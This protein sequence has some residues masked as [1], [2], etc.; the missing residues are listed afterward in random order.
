MASPRTVLI[1]ILAAA[2]AALG[3]GCAAQ[4]DK[5]PVLSAS[6]LES[7]PAA[8]GNSPAA[9]LEFFDQL[10]EQKLVCHDD[11]VHAVLLL[12][13][14]DGARSF[15]QRVDQARK[16]GLIDAA[17]DRPAREAV[18]IG[19]VSRM[20]V[21]VVD[22]PATTGRLSQERAVSRLVTRGWLPAQ[23]KSYQGLTGAQFVTL[24][25][26]ARDQL[27]SSGRTPPPMAAAEQ[28]APD[29]PVARPRPEPLP[30]VAA[31][32]ERPAAAA[33][34]P[35]P[36]VEPTPAPPKPTTPSPWVPGRP[37]RKPAA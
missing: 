32:P 37:I 15:S 4:P 5:R 36:R 34:P 8:A 19:D 22:D 7:V 33:P 27:A 24:V 23:A 18:T 25:A 17:F 13:G 10:A 12:T 35:A 20:L 3:W 11:A 2:C 9:E 1:A 21:L 29:A 28:R 31:E 30:V 26:T 14:G 16:S 6:V